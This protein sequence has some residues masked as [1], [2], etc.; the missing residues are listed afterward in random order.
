MKKM[1][2]KYGLE[3][4]CNNCHPFHQNSLHHKAYVKPIAKKKIE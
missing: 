2:A 1:E 3:L 4:N